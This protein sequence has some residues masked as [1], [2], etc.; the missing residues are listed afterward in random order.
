MGAHRSPRR[1]VFARALVG[2]A[3]VLVSLPIVASTAAG[4]EVSPPTL[5]VT[6]AGNN[7]IGR[8]GALTFTSPSNLANDP[9]W[10]TPGSRSFDFQNFVTVLANG[11][12]PIGTLPVQRSQ[13][14]SG[15]PFFVSGSL[16]VPS[17]LSGVVTWTLRQS[18]NDGLG[19]LFSRPFSFDLTPFRCPNLAANANCLPMG[20]GSMTFTGQINRLSA[21][22]DVGFDV[23][24]ST[25]KTP[26]TKIVRAVGNTAGDGTFNVTFNTPALS[27]GPHTFFVGSGSFDGTDFFWLPDDQNTKVIVSVPIQVPCPPDALTISPGAF[28]FGEVNVGASS[29]AAAFA[30]VNTGQRPAT[31]NGVSITPVGEFAIDSNACAATLA[32]GATCAVT[33]HFTPGASGPRSAT[34][35]ATSTG[36]A[37]A[38]SALSGTG[39]TPPGLSISP[40]TKNF[41]S[42][43][44]RGTSAATTFTVKNTGSQPQTITSVAL[45]TGQPDQF[46][47]DPG[48]CAGAVVPGGGT[49][50]VNAAFTPT[51]SGARTTRLVVSSNAN[52][53]ATATLRGTGQPGRLGFEPNP[54]DYGV[55]AIGST[56]NAVTVTITNG[57]GGVLGVTAV[58]VGGAN[59]GE[60]LVMSDSCTGQQLAPAGTCTVSVAFRPL[61]TGTRT[62]S[63]DVDHSDGTA[64]AV[65]R[66]VG[67]FQ[68]ILKFTPPVVS[69]GSLATVV[70]QSF[71]ANTT[72]T[73]QWQEAGIAAPLQVTTDGG[74]AFRQSFVIL[75][76]ERLGPRHLEPAPDPGVLNEPRPVAALLVQAPTFRPQSVAV[77]GGGFNLNLVSRG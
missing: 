23:D 69:A 16:P 4:G 30:V 32:P 2:L 14:P 62:G 40:T 70:G 33:V 50:T 15:F 46:A 10:F 22:I 64:S 37:T 58:R 51:A 54:A 29:G 19:S 28:N 11:T 43:P 73:L 76:G 8:G 75:V 52:V 68:A 45:N 77:R 63:L 31:I 41:G 74:G 34:L 20:G 66:G 35:T 26:I 1:G 36:G 71:P 9:D 25:A 60:F 65:L 49:C 42:V 44:E 47:L 53:S 3:L 27:A 57:G 17:G 48:T 39:V 13:S 61:G 18:T 6:F 5:S 7:C 67:I 59:A 55:V 12:T 72:I 38:S 24:L 21:P 56:T